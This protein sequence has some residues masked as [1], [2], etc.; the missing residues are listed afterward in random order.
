MTGV[1]FPDQGTALQKSLNPGQRLVSPRGD[2]WRWDGYAASSE[3]Q[4]PGAVHLA[5]RNRLT[6][7]ENKIVAAKETRGGLFERY[8]SARDNGAIA[9]EAANTADQDDRKA[10][11]NLITAQSASA[12]AARAAGERLSQ[13]AS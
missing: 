2:L 11:Q 8:S 6:E 4:S 12:E 5:Q 7:L 9:R 13:F 3:A 1:V 10:A